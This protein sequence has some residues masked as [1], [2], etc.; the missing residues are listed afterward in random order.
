MKGDSN[1]CEVEFVA[2]VGQ[3]P[4]K[5]EKIERRRK[6]VGKVNAVEVVAVDSTC[7]A[8]FRSTI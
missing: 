7:L 4:T 1:A 2:Y 6:I 8:S 5:R 3:R